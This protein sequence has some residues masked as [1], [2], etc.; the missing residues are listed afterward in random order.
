M[1]ERT[2][3]HAFFRYRATATSGPGEP[4]KEALHGETV[5]IPHEQCLARGHE[6]GAF[7]EVDIKE[8]EYEDMTVLQLRTVAR[9]VG[10]EA[11]SLRKAELI[12]ALR[13]ADKANAEAAEEKAS[14]SDEEKAAEEKASESDE[15]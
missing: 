8:L 14:Q 5:D 6:H 2:I 9:T 10:V 13:E 12:E 1:A 4:M 3:A 15:E 11:G 7:V